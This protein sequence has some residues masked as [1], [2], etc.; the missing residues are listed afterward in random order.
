MAI[1]SITYVNFPAPV[2]KLTAHITH[3]E[4][5]HFDHTERCEQ[6]RLHALEVIQIKLVENGGPDLKLSEWAEYLLS[7][8]KAPNVRVFDSGRHS[9]EVTGI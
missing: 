1:K 9:A 3:H 4:A 2:A 8:L 5:G 6:V 7:E